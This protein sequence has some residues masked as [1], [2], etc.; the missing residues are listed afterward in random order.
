MHFLSW[1]ERNYLVPKLLGFAKKK[2]KKK[3]K[4]FCVLPHSVSK[5][6]GLCDVTSISNDVLLIERIKSKTFVLKKTYCLI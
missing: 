2:K 6:I 1:N 3:K 4:L 5:I